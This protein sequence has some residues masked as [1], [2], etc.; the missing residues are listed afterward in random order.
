MSSQKMRVG[1]GRWSVGIN[2]WP[3]I[4]RIALPQ[5]MGSFLRRARDVT[6]RICEATRSTAVVY[7]SL[8]IS[9]SDNSSSAGR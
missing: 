9:D 5:Q 4:P 6:M 2:V 7:L 8:V 3:A 1:R